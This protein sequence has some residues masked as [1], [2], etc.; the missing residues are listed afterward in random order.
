MQT[1]KSKRPGEDVFGLAVLA[2]SLAL[3]WQS[4]SISGFSSLS[5]PGA[6]PLAASAAMVLGSLLVVRDNLRR[7]RAGAK[8]DRT[9]VVNLTGILF[10]ILIVAYAVL[11]S[12][13]GFLLSSFLFLM[14]SMT[15]L[16]RGGLLKTLAV[17]V[18]T[19]AVIY[20]IFRLVFQVV[21]PEGIVP[22][23]EIMAAIGD[24]FGGAR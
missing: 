11:L 7:N 24:F 10:T 14:A 9:P 5:S 3:F 12:P 13:L 17:V 15:L 21:L 16:Y 19:L 20:V 18:P 8:K 6:F 2:V 22:E 23:R 4:Y 1:I